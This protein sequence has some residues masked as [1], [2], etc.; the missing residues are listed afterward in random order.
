MYDDDG[1]V[2]TPSQELLDRID[3]YQPQLE[4]LEL[5]PWNVVFPLP[6]DALDKNPNLVQNQGYGAAE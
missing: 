4:F 3:R 5:D 6:Q 1:N 2:F